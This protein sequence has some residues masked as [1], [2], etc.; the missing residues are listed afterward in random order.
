[1]AIG[2]KRPVVMQS[3][4]AAN[5]GIATLDGTGNV[6]YAQLGNAVRS[7]LLHTPYFANPVNQRGQTEYIGAGYTIDRW[8]GV[9]ETSVV[10]IENGITLKGVGG[11]GY[12]AQKMENP[13]MMIGEHTLAFLVTSIS[14]T[15]YIQMVGDVNGTKA[16][17]AITSPGLYFVTNN[18]D[19]KDT[20]LRAQIRISDGGS[21]TLKA[22]KLELGSTQTLAHQENG[23]WVL[24]EIPD[25]GEELAKCQ[26]FYQLFTTAEKRPADKRDFRPE[27]RT[28]ATSAN[29]GT[30]EINGV[31]YY[32]ASAEL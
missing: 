17:A 24:N 11:Y 21:V 28:N 1:M 32:Y 10:T 12:F 9:V 26:R 3:D 29:T 7:N 18:L 27:L 25:F 15:A 20:S 5:D 16:S 22:A 13:Q 4:R 6:P 19:G 8:Y 30:V 14:G 23:V 31:T 2:D